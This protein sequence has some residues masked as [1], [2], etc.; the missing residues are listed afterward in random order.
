MRPYSSN[1]DAATVIADEADA[2]EYVQ[3]FLPPFPA[4]TTIGIPAFVA[5]STALFNNIAFRSVPRDM[6]TTIGT[7]GSF[8]F[9]Y[10]TYSNAAMMSLKRDLPSAPKTFNATRFTSFATPYVLPPVQSKID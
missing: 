7:L 1:V 4:A 2:G 9:R 10:I 6:L 5:L 3:A 8:F